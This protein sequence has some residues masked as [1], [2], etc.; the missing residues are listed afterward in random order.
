[1]TSTQKIA[2]AGAVMGSLAVVLIKKV[3]DR[4]EEIENYEFVDDVP[5]LQPIRDAE[6]QQPEPLQSDD[7]FVAQNSPL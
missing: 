6:P 3:F 5:V 2:I 7:L 4:V 1:M